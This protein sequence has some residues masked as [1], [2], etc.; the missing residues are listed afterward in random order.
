MSDVVIAAEGVGKRYRLGAATQP[1]NTL[2]ESVSGLARVPV[3]LA[4]RGRRSPPRP[5]FW[6]LRDL[7]LKVE[8]G[9]VLGIIGRNGAGKSTLLKLISEITEPTE[10]RISVRGR[11]A[12][13]LEVG[14]GFHPELT[15]RE[16]VY[17]NGA[18]LGMRKQD[19][20]AKFDEIVSFAEVEKFVDTPV[21]RFSS[22]MYLRLA[23]AVA[24]HLESEILLVD[25]V[26]AVGDAGFQR[27]CVGKIGTAARS[28]RT[29][30]FV[31]HNLGAVT[32]LCTS[33]VW[34]DGGGIRDR[35]EPSRLV[36]EYSVDS[37]ENGSGERVWDSGMSS[38]GVGEFQL[39][40][41][42]LCDD[43]G[44]AGT[45]FDAQAPWRLEIRY[46]VNSALPYC[47]VGMLLSAV[48]GTVVTEAYDID[49]ERFAG[50]R[51]P[52]EY[53]TTCRIPGHLIEPG[54]YLVSVNVG[55]PGF[56][57]LAMEDVA[58]VSIENTY[59]EY[60][61]FQGDRAG[62][63]RAPLQWERE[64]LLGSESVVESVGTGMR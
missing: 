55:I 38:A 50:R 61:P 8:R 23:F 12:S 46:R 2:R 21:K 54:R 41:V 28:G 48:D 17:L 53:V 11:V 13:L 44:A 25:E 63:I 24:A 33:V 57:K 20:T 9:E 5:E 1:Y 58:T 40:S 19:I 32:R 43:S 29:V 39:Q 56:K 34:L 59:P 7:N 47:R 52:G 31:S 27:K 16:N 10:G 49:D 14:T 3:R 22:G 42:R 6:A 62:V 18:I 45:S 4:R 51:E 35:G 36:R 15:G 64:E 30:F 26:L 37:G 60:V